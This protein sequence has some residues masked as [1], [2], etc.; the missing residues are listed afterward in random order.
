MSNDL[1]GGMLSDSHI[2]EA[3]HNGSIKVTPAPSSAQIQPASL[4]ITLGGT[5]VLKYRRPSS[6]FGVP[7]IVPGEDQADQME[8]IP[9]EEDGCIIL[10]PGDFLLGTTQE[11][12]G[13]PNNIAARVEGKSS[14]GRIGLIIHGTA[15]FI[16]PGFV[17]NIT[18]EISNIAPRP[19]KLCRTMRIGQIAFFALTGTAQ[20]P[21]GSE[22]LGSKYQ[23]QS[24]RTAARGRVS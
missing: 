9:F 12:V 18:L 16:D 2:T 8:H 14:L 7:V 17:G 21:Y 20:R 4:D 13:L 22:G 23:G 24:D 3:I 1:V 5:G 6:A 10:M 15:G 19:I 11:R